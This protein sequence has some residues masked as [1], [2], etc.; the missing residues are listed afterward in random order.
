MPNANYCTSM[1][2]SDARHRFIGFA[3]IRGVEDVVDDYKVVEVDF[4]PA[5]RAHRTR[6]GID[7]L[8]IKVV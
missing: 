5:I 6:R 1:L 2:T 3:Y 8:L 7:V 4:M